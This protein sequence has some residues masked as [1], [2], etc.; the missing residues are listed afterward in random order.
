MLTDYQLES[1]RF[2]RTHYPYHSINR[3]DDENDSCFILNGDQVELVDTSNPPVAFRWKDL[4]QTREEFLAYNPPV[5]KAIQEMIVEERL[6]QD[7]K[8]GPARTMNPFKWAAILT[9]EVGEV[10]SAC[11]EQDDENL[12]E[13]L[14][15]VAAVALAWLERLYDADN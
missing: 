13:E 9:E 15:Q 1:L 12:K 5:R 6:K 2:L 4:Y 10:S 8:W 7:I 3:I 11:L 14:I